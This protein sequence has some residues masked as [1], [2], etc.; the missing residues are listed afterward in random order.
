MTANLGAGHSKAP[1]E[2]KPIIEYLIL[3][4]T[5]AGGVILVLIAASRVGQYWKEVLL[6]LGHALVIAALVGFFVEM[7][8]IKEALQRMQA[9]HANTVAEIKGM[10]VTGLRNYLPD[11][12]VDALEKQMLDPI[13][14]REEF[15]ISIELQVEE[16]NGEKCV[17]GSIALTY[18]VKNISKKVQNH[19]VRCNLDEVLG[20]SSACLE[21]VTINEKP[22][23][24]SDLPIG[25]RI[26]RES[27]VLRFEHSIAISEGDRTHVQIVGYQRMALRD[28]WP[29]HMLTPSD[30]LKVNVNYPR[31]LEVW[32]APL[33]PAAEDGRDLVIKT[34]WTAQLFINNIV[35]PY[36]GFELRWW[37]QLKVATKEMESIAPPRLLGENKSKEIGMHAEAKKGEPPGS[38]II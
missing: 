36:Q 22:V 37:P 34:P 10:V 12:L 3:A 7:R 20:E 6:G 32:L 2:D 30:S 28:L 26:Y 23:N 15:T 35:L 11:K 13:F 25:S 29:W 27:N 31:D 18:F 1:R 8:L 4:L 17:K 21:S 9:V 24:L 19:M 16:E 33:H 38:A 5:A 14:L